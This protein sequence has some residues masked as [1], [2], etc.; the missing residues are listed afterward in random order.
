MP[1]DIKHLEEYLDLHRANGWVAL[2][3]K[4]EFSLLDFRTP[5]LAKIVDHEL[6]LFTIG[7]TKLGD[8]MH[9]NDTIR[10]IVLREGVDILKGF[11]TNG[12]YKPKKEYSGFSLQSLNNSQFDRII[13]QVIGA[14]TQIQHVID[15]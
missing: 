8:A 12:S 6:F 9:L 4:A 2:H 5:R 1:V 3:P 10:S 7:A 14:I 15:T 11:S 13:L